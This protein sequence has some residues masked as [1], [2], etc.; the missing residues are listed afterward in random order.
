MDFAFWT[1]GVPAEAV[2]TLPRNRVTAAY[3]S[4]AWWDFGAGWL[5]KEIARLQPIAPVANTIGLPKTP[6]SGATVR[7][8]AQRLLDVA[9]DNGHGI[10]LPMGFEFGLPTDP[11]HPGYGTDDWQRLREHTQF[12]LSP[13]IREANRRLAARKTSAA[14]PEILSAENAP[15]AV[16]LEQPAQI[17]LA[18]R[19]LHRG[20]TFDPAGVLPMLDGRLRRLTGPEGST[21]DEQAIPLAPGE[22]RVFTGAPARPIRTAPPREARPRVHP[23][24]RRLLRATSASRVAIEAIEPAVDAGRFRSQTNGRRAGDGGRR[25]SS[26]MGTARSLPSCSGA[27]G[28]RVPGTKR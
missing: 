23:L 26:P 9:A 3:N 15:V 27:P 12:D 7:Q 20:A 14:A 25:T 16:L 4:L 13:A 28:T 1:P 21:F 6:T 22:V 2:G 8:A 5:R 19:Y 18:N 10:L 17:T 11:T 24:Q